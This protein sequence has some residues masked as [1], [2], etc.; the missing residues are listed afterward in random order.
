[1]P[2]E[3]WRATTR[4]CGMGLATGRR[5]DYLV[6]HPGRRGVSGLGEE[7]TG[8]TCRELLLGSLVAMVGLVAVAT[9]CNGPCV[10]WWECQQQTCEGK[11]TDGGGGSVPDGGAV[12]DSADVCGTLSPGKMLTANGEMMPTGALRAMFTVSIGW[13]LPPSVFS[14]GPTVSVSPTSWTV[15]QVQFSPLRPREVGIQV[16]FPRGLGSSASGTITVT[17]TIV[18]S[19]SGRPWVV[20]CAFD[21][22]FSARWAGGKWELR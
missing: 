4:Q 21:R 13:N 19:G 15:E 2:G 17:G 11:A 6:V 9:G 10:E 12:L 20:R 22:S 8:Q 5:G 3:S 1:M 7:M 14:P 18:V 16:F